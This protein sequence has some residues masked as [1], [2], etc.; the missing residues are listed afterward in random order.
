[1]NKVRVT[2][3]TVIEYEVDPVNYDLRVEPD[4]NIIKACLDSDL[5][6]MRDDHDIF[7]ELADLRAVS[8]IFAG[9]VIL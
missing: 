2:M 9:E 5:E 8:F 3:T 1:M 6:A 7:L 4:E